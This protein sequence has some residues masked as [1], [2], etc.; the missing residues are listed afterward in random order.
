MVHRP[1]F[2]SCMKGTSL[3]LMRWFLPVV[4]SLGTISVTGQLAA[5]V[6]QSDKTDPGGR[7]DPE[8]MH[9]GIVDSLVKDLSPGRKE[10]VDTDFP[11]LVKDFTGFKSRVLQGGDPFAAARKLASGKWHLGVFQGVEFAW[12]QAGDPKLRPLLVAINKEPTNH[13]L[14]VTKKDSSLK[15]FAD[16]KG[17]SVYLL[18]SR[19]HCRLFADKGA[20]GD[21]KSFFGKLTRTSAA[22][23][24]LDDVL[25]GKVQAAVVDVTALELY[26]LV[27]PGR[28][29]RLKVLAKSEPFPPTVVAYYQG[30]LSDAV[31]RKFRAGMQKANESDKGKDAM[32]SVR[33][34]AFEAVPA[35]FPKMLANIA[36]AYPAPG[37]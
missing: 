11:I 3:Q 25:R 17:K 4:L 34:T 35:D 10:I 24:A 33:I 8:V 36:K 31:L 26:K 5:A 21:A 30:G 20:G 16:L 2:C 13:A 32:S 19:A 15:G 23:D 9:I 14:L 12:A 37:K 27:N 28:F 6:L 18:K 1:F 7:T 22:E 29:E